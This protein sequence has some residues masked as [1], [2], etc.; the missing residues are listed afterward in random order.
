VLLRRGI[1]LAFVVSALQFVFETAESIIDV[2]TLIIEAGSEPFLRGL[3][4]RPSEGN[5]FRPGHAE[6]VV[7]RSRRPSFLMRRT[8]SGQSLLS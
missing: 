8:R 6:M 3:G 4:K 2:T 5:I 7:V 1:T